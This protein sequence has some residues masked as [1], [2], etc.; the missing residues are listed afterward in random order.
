MFDGKKVVVCTPVGRKR[1]LEILK[2]YILPN[3]H[4]DEW[5]LWENCRDPLDKMYLNAL[6]VDP[7]VRIIQP[8][9]ANSQG[10]NKSI[11]QF[12]KLYSNPDEI[13]FKLDDDIVY[14]EDCYFENTLKFMKNSGNE[15]SFYYPVIINNAIVSWMIQ[16]FSAVKIPHPLMCSANC[17]TG[18]Q[19][20]LFAEAMHRGFLGLL[21]RGQDRIASFKFKPRPLFNVR[22]SINAFSWYGEFAKQLAADWVPE[23]VDDEDW[24]SAYIPAKYL[25]PEVVMGDSIVSHF[26]FYPQEE[27]L[28]KTDILGMYKEI[29]EKLI[30]AA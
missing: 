15:Y 25:K 14:I 30:A 16:H 27:H 4:V 24:I 2:H 10:V 21:K 22:I 23:G 28:L 5:H 18:W 3:A 11:N 17:P 8:P 7:K 12:Y 13:Y 26:A 1:Y 29:A 19:S 20:A 6:A 9:L